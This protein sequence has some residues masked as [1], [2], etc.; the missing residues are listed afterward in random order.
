M[1]AVTLDTGIADL[2][3]QGNEFR[4]RRLAAMEARVEAGD[5]RHTGETLPDRVDRREIVGLV[6]WRQRDEGAQLLEDLRRD[7]GWTGVARTA[8]NDAVADAADVGA[9]ITPAQPVGD[10]TNRR[11]TVLD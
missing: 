10:E 6:Q 4:D 8:M 11:S 5:L 3:R 7:D 2:A 9:T 1:E